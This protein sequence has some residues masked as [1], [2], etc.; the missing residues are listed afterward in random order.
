MT[1][2]ICFV[3]SG[4]MT[5]AIVGGLR[6]IDTAQTAQIYVVGRK[7]ESSTNKLQA[8]VEAFDVLSL[9]DDLSSLPA[10]L[11]LLVLCVKPSQFAAAAQHLHSYKIPA[12]C[13]VLQTDDSL[14]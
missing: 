9:T 8:L 11:D 10:D 3:G 14:G 4:S 1:K 12:D 6:A 13:V 7:T 5:K 2:S